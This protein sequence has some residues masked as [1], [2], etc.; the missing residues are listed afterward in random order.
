LTW[1]EGFS[2][3]NYILKAIGKA[4][5]K[6]VDDKGIFH[7]ED[8][9]ELVYPDPTKFAKV[10]DITE[11]LFS[12]DQINY[13]TSKRPIKEDTTPILKINNVVPE[14]GTYI[15]DYISGIVTF[16]SKHSPG[17][18]VIMTYDWDDD[19][20]EGALNA[21]GTGIDQDNERVIFK[22]TT[23]PVIITP[24]AKLQNDI[25]DPSL[26]T[27]KI[28]M[29]V[30]LYKPKY[31]INP[32]TGLASY[33]DEN[34]TVISTSRN[35]HH[36]MCR[37]FDNYTDI[38]HILGEV[39]KPLDTQYQVYSLFHNNLMHTT[40]N[41]PVVKLNGQLL[42]E[43]AGDIIIVNGVEYKSGI[44]FFTGID[45]ATTVTALAQAIA[46][47]GLF[48]QSV[49]ENTVI[50]TQVTPSTDM[51]TVTLSEGSIGVISAV[52]NNVVYN[53]GH[54]VI[55]PIKTAINTPGLNVN[56]GVTYS[57]QNLTL[58]ERSI[59]MTSTLT[60]NGS[61]TA[62]TITQIKTAL[63][64]DINAVYTGADSGETFVVGDDG[65]KLTIT[66]ARAGAT[67]T[68]NLNG[69]SPGLSGALGFTDISP[70]YGQD[71]VLP[72]PA[73]FR[74][75][76]TENLAPGDY[77]IGAMNGTITFPKVNLP[78]DKVT[79]D[80]DYIHNGPVPDVI[81]SYGN[82]VTR[83]AHVSDWAKFSWFRDWEE[84][85]I[86]LKNFTGGIANLAGGLLLNQIQIP[87]LIDGIPI[88]FWLSV[89]KN[90][91]VLILM[92][93]PSID[94]ENYL[95]SFGYFGK[96]E[97][98]PKSVNDTAGNFAMSVGS[99]TI[100]AKLGTIP[101]EKVIINS[102]TA[103]IDVGGNHEGG[104][105]YSYIVTFMDDGGESPA[106]SPMAIYADGSPATAN[107][108]IFIEFKTP[109][110]SKGWRIYRY[111]VEGDKTT[112]PSINALANYKLVG[113]STDIGG[114][115]SWI[116]SD[117]TI[118]P[119]DSIPSYYGTPTP[120][121][122]RDPL[123]GLVT[124]IKY[125]DKWGLD[126]ATGVGDVAM[127]KTRG[128][129]FFQRHR[130]AFTTPEEFMSK[131]AFN[132]SR[133]TGHFHLSLVNVLHL[134][135][136]HRGALD[137]V[138]AVDSISIA[139]LDELTVDKGKVEV[140]E[141]V[142]KG[143]SLS[144]GVSE[145]VFND[146][147]TEA[148]TMKI[149]GKLPAATAQAS[150]ESEQIGTLIDPPFNKVTLRT[151]DG[152]PVKDV[153]TREIYGRMSWDSSNNCFRIDLKTIDQSS[154]EIDGVVAVDMDDVQLTYSARESVE[155]YYKYFTI[156]APH[157]MLTNSPNSMYGLAI[158][159]S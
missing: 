94:T 118:L 48:T 79:V 24:E 110:Y 159:K 32:E 86:G 123:F 116:D 42:G 117:V 34:G 141:K 143:V 63:Q 5:C 7:D 155:K 2:N 83:G 41:S 147:S 97:A 43:G 10:T 65:T 89:N 59:P 158:K 101:K 16:Y 151:S 11:A 28:T 25:I 129:A 152:Q 53:A 35:Q 45:A 131:N 68:V 92:G 96:L 1:T 106:S 75:T 107:V 64:N 52:T 119:T 37:I 149:V 56:Y 39:A 50:L 49:S 121:V 26:N 148:Q 98:L 84:I 146:F 57:G 74:F 4:I 71:E 17:D 91:L 102:I 138:L 73:E 134:F 100:P 27:E 70:V 19:G 29:Y 82:V 135:D 125:P 111:K 40:E 80:Y 22:T 108:S 81:D 115:V 130:I 6:P 124:D 60:L 122:V 112:D 61:V 139:P 33:K 85:N 133:W 14:I 15:I 99:S 136:G 69:S 55:S 72:T 156:N 21:I 78:T 150:S 126:T 87:N 95:C 128:G 62:L 142:I 20:V 9:W 137:G 127:F 113:R 104:T 157:S 3:S 109:L 114:I 46:A 88:Q 145:M 54:P 90:R 51:L 36:I 18:V 47:D 30:E 105:T 144:T 58:N 103:R 13:K 153:Q 77:T 140:I 76:I 12:T 44:D 120:G 31:L 38:V 67:A 23:Y 132:P 8:K 93:E 154:A 66:S